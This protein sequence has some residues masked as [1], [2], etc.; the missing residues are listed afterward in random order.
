MVVILYYIRTIS[1]SNLFRATGIWLSN[2]SPSSCSQATLTVGILH[3]YVSHSIVSVWSLTF[4]SDYLH[5]SRL[6]GRTY[7]VLISNFLSSLYSSACSFALRQVRDS[8]C[9]CWSIPEARGLARML[10]MKGPHRLL[11]IS[12]TVAETP[13]VN[14]RKCELSECRLVFEKSL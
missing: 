3:R 12:L 11:A 7:H 8:C 2:R 1:E 6:G 14:S 13:P 4:D 5:W 9:W 10:I